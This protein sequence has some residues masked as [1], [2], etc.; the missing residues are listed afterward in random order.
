[1]KKKNVLAPIAAG[2]ATAAAAYS[3]GGGLAL[4]Y[5]FC[6]GK[7][8]ITIAPENEAATK[9]VN[10]ITSCEEAPTPLLKRTR[11]AMRS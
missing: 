2:G 8:E 4:Y 5:A 9:E 1:M 7:H 3:L 11:I 10:A 6:R